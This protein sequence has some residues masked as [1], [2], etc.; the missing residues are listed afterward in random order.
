MLK[1]KQSSA[2]C[3]LQNAC[4]PRELCHTVKWGLFVSSINLQP[5]SVSHLRTN[6]PPQPVF[7][8]QQA[9][10]R[11]ESQLW[12]RETECTFKVQCF[13]VCVLFFYVPTTAYTQVFIHWL[14]QV[15]I[16]LLYLVEMWIEGC[17]TTAVM[18]EGRG[19]VQKSV[20]RWQAKL[21]DVGYF[22]MFVNV[23][24]AVCREQLFTIEHHTLAPFLSIYLAR[25][26]LLS[27]Q[28]PNHHLGK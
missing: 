17:N 8:C 19:A 20:S 18:K 6:Y 12:L 23:C 13:L 14:L 10:K 28:I 21:L 3:Q 15:C 4:K 22:W 2:L 9:A 5:V 16:Y 1:L 27:L 25:I 11:C 24:L 7:P 26:P